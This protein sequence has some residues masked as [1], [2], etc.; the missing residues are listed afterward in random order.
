MTEPKYIGRN[1]TSIAT[2]RFVDDMWEVIYEIGE[3]RSQDLETWEEEKVAAKGIDSSFGDAYGTALKSAIAQFNQRLE[4][5]G[6][7]TL[8]ITG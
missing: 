5:T 4:E 3:Q 2:A 8:F 7:D 6:R 1:L